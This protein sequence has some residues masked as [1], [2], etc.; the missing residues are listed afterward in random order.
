M[1]R[2]SSVIVMSFERIA[3]R[4]SLLRPAIHGRKCCPRES[5][6]SGRIARDA[7]ERNENV[8]KILT[9]I[10]AVALAQAQR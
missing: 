10:V 5:V 1:L 8:Q 4:R 3:F 9:S 6:K 2:R 7:V